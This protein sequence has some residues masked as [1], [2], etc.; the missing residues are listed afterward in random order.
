MKESQ[1]ELSNAYKAVM[2]DILKRHNENNI[3]YTSWEE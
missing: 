1:P 2:D 3:N